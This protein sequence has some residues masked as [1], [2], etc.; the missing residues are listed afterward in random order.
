MLQLIE[1][2]LQQ[3]WRVTFASAA[4]L[5][6][7]RI[8]L[9]EL[10][11]EEKA[12]ALNCSSFDAYLAE[13]QP[14]MVVFDRFVTE[15]QFGWRVANTCP[16]A[17][18]VLDTEDLHSLR[19]VRH[20]LLKRQQQ[21][22]ASEAERYQ[23]Y[24]P[25]EELT[26]LFDAMADTET[27]QRELAAIY[28]CDIS[29]IIS[30]FEYELLQG[31]FA[32]PS[33]LLHYCP[34]LLQPEPLSDPGFTQRQDFITIGNFR[35]EPNWDAV[36]CLKHQI[37]PRLRAR[38]PQATLR[39]YGAYPPPKATALHNPKQGFFIE[40]WAEDAHQVMRQ[41]RVCL[42]PL[43]F[44]AG[45]KGKLIDAMQCG[46]PSVTTSIGAEGLQGAGQWPGAIADE[47]G[48]F[49]DAAADL[50]ES[51]DTWQSAH[52]ACAVTLQQFDS[53]PLTPLLIEKLQNTAA[54]LDTHR[55]RNFTGAMLQHHQHKSTQYMGLWIE[56]KNKVSL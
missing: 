56:A 24:Q 45:L 2:F 23:L 1:C 50:Y 15:E 48:L 34:F 47:I 27:A 11:V 8:R 33:A 22:A 55:R 17:L 14:D 46:T 35:H 44:G 30:R 5:S 54:A 38:L 39:I 28:R 18:R 10:G 32:V 43:R 19:H 7:H 21:S 3:N 9:S 6:E 25:E 12:I 37:W 13:L 52:Q 51:P 31:E 42:A 41:A 53:G 49:V 16:Q 29:L 36:L 40:G 4:N 20:Q 26:T